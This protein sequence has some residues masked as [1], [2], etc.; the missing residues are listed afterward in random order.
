MISWIMKQQKTVLFSRVAFI[1]IIYE[2]VYHDNAII[3]QRER[4]RERKSTFCCLGC[5]I[6]DKPRTGLRKCKAQLIKC[7]CSPVF[8]QA[9]DQSFHFWLVRRYFQKFIMV[10]S[11]Q[12]IFL[13]TRIY[14]SLHL[15]FVLI[16]QKIAYQRQRNLFL[17]Y[18]HLMKV[19][20][21]RLWKIQKVNCHPPLQYIVRH[22]GILISCAAT[23]YLII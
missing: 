4:E 9:V 10:K 3:F 21:P 6:I 2:T 17:W 13:K 18:I 23:N 11:L 22:T 12:N 19:I 20:F 5:E 14:Q 7:I 16:P 15:T 8:S 1:H